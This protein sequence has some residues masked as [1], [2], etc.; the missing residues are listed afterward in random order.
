MVI[1]TAPI[2]EVT[3]NYTSEEIHS[4]YDVY[5]NRDGSMSRAFMCS[6]MNQEEM[7]D[8]VRIIT[9]L[10]N[11]EVAVLN[12]AHDKVFIGGF[13][14]GCA[15]SLATFLLYKEGRLGGVLGLCGNYVTTIDYDTEVD[16]PLKRQ[17]KIFL[18]HG[19]DDTNIY[20]DA[21]MKSY[22]ELKELKL[23]FT[24]DLE[25]GCGHHFSNTMI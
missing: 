20:T 23:D 18:Y 1:P 8:S 7:R 14:Q 15:M 9:E 2:R 3:G 16:L 22:E 6:L 10:V 4:W 17:T 12:G 5:G 11:Q 24:F 25:P 13:S 19:E 21:A